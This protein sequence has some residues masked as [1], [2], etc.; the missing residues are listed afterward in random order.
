[1]STPPSAAAGRELELPPELERKLYDFRS[2][3]WRIKLGEALCGA[4]CGVLAGYLV[5]FGLD[6]VAETPWWVRGVAFALAV[7]A[8][9]T[10]QDKRSAIQAV[11]KAFQADY[12][13]MLA[14]QGLRSYKVRR[15]DAFVALHATMARL[16]GNVLNRSI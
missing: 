1:M 5:V 14:D 8:C 15:G 11:N 13:A 6:R 4:A 3:V 10:D 7:A 2:L 12:E 9:A 16:G